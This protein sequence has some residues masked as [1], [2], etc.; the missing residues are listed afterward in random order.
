MLRDAHRKLVFIKR[1]S[2]LRR[3]LRRGKS[4]HKLKQSAIEATDTRFYLP[5]FRPGIR[6][7]SGR[8]GQV[9]IAND[10]PLSY[11]LIVT[12]R[13]NDGDLA[14]IH[15]II[16]SALAIHLRFE[17][18]DLT[19]QVND[20]RMFWPLNSPCR[21]LGNAFRRKGA[22]KLFGLKLEDAVRNSH[23]PST[24]LLPHQL[25]GRNRSE[26]N[27]GKDMELGLNLHHWVESSAIVHQEESA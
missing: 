12:P 14:G 21:Q 16:E 17:A 24:Y 20:E 27:K 10:A 13:G 5:W 8:H 23:L 7:Q 15:R 22:R 25:V 1:L 18:I 6:L 4:F 26:R 3:R 9:R 2:P 19:R 11:R